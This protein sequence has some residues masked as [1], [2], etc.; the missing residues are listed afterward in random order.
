MDGSLCLQIGHFGRVHYDE[1]IGIY[2]WHR[3][4]RRMTTYDQFGSLC[5]RWWW[6]S[7]CQMVI[8]V[9]PWFINI[10]WMLGHWF[11]L[12]HH[13]LCQVCAPAVV[14][15]A[16]LQQQQQIHPRL[17]QTSTQL[18]FKAQCRIETTF[19]GQTCSDKHKLNVNVMKTS[20]ATVSPIIYW[21][22]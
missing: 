11:H 12:L 1:M 3:Y 7:W 13:Y 5:F 4:E 2:W 8:L 16:R 6:W 21:S 14:P 18:Q 20:E 9:W 17:H 10:E 15:P 22:C 19:R